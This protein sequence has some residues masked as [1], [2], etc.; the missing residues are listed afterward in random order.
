MRGLVLCLCLALSACPVASE[1]ETVAVHIRTFP[2]DCEVYCWR[3]D[4][5][6]SLQ[7][8][9][10]SSKRELSIPKL[11]EKN[12]ELYFI[13]HPENYKVSN[14]KRDLF[15]HRSLEK[16]DFETP[17]GDGKPSFPRGAFPI[18][19]LHDFAGW[20]YFLVHNPL[21]AIVPLSLL[22]A[23]MALWR[24]RPRSVLVEPTAPLVT[25][26][27]RF[28]LGKSLGKG[29][30]GEVFAAVD[31]QGEKVAVKLLHSNLQED[32]QG[33]K[34]FLR[35]VQVC[36]KLNHPNVVKLI[37]WGQQ[38]DLFYLV[39][40]L[41]EG[42]SLGESLRRRGPFSPSELLALL[43]PLGSALQGLHDLGLIHRD[44]KP[45]NIFLRRRGAPA[46]MDF[47]IAT[48]ED[49]TRA[50]R[51]GLSLGTPTYMSPEQIRG[52]AVAASDQY[53]LGVLAFVCLTG[54]RPFEADDPVAM[55]YQHV[56]GIAP[57]PSSLCAGLST[58]IDSV[59]L[60]ML[61]KRPSERYS[62]VAEAIQ[63]LEEVISPSL[64]LEEAT[65]ETEL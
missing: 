63:R 18:F 32:P 22:W 9:G 4:Q 14:E 10:N 2:S 61:A 12:T 3:P 6:P 47:G 29:G 42:E 51:T 27:G 17:G 20:R 65:Q 37:D 54:K 40:E 39:M 62:S 21:Y 38:G 7:P 43:K 36:S 52:Q 44:I 59:V 28:E 60:K 24:R 35:E 16:A 57:A 56:H 8:L 31:D 49:L 1:Q 5:V 23:A 58:G 15:P 19:V 26:V 33:H 53:S 48:G 64:F 13:Y 34:R 50:T 55:A 45:D 46:L 11:G 41:L 30:A 25:K